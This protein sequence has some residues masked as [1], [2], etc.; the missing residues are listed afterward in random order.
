MFGMMLLQWIEGG[1]QSEASWEFF[2]LVMKNQPVE[3][4]TRKLTLSL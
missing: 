4:S 2:G 1:F 3:K